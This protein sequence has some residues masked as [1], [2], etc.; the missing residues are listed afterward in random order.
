[1]NTFIQSKTPRPRHYRWWHF[2]VLLIPLLG[3]GYVLLASQLNRSTLEPPDWKVGRGSNRIV[4][5][6]PETP[7]QFQEDLLISG[8]GGVDDPWQMSRGP[9]DGGRFPPPRYSIQALTELQWH[10][11]ELL[12]D[13]WCVDPP[14]F[15]LTSARTQPYTIVFRCDETLVHFA[16]LDVPVEQLPN[17]IRELLVEVPSPQVAT[18]KPM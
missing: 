11:L 1:M 3:A 5:R 12:R 7:G 16:R 2:I 17:I 13:Q 18:P 4:I 14:A 10:Q 6:L 9:A 15:S 8:T